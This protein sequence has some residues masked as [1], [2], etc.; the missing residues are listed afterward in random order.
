MGSL[1]NNTTLQPYCLC[2]IMILLLWSD[3]WKHLLW[4]LLKGN[5]LTLTFN[6]TS[7]PLLKVIHFFYDLTNI[8]TFLARLHPSENV[9]STFP[10]EIYSL[11]RLR[12][13]LLMSDQCVRP[14]L[15]QMEIFFLSVLTAEALHPSSSGDVL[16]RTAAAGA[17]HA[18]WHQHR[19]V[20]RS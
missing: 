6:V 14:A 17:R 20:C 11:H 15:W 12:C 18:W 16:Y 8:K 5:S 9:K 1:Q 4:K 10:E 19:A 7:F 3:L 2:Y 13:V